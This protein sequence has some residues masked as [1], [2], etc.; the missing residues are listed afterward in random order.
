MRLSKKRKR[1]REREREESEWRKEGRESG[2]VSPKNEV[3]HKVQTKDVCT[4][5]NMH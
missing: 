3:L 4:A 5:G 1:V 2:I